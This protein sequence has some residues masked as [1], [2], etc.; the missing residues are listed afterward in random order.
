MGETVFGAGRKMKNL[1][2]NLRKAGY[3]KDADALE[4]SYKQAQLEDTPF[5]PVRKKL[6]LFD[7]Q[8]DKEKAWHR[9]KGHHR[10]Q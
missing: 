1:I 10:R 6:Q 3:T 2:K 8:L 9:S 4:K 7:P 5:K